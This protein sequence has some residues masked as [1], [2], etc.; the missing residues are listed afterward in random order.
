MC[1]GMGGFFVVLSTYTVCD[2]DGINIKSCYIVM[3]SLQIQISQIMSKIFTIIYVHLDQDG[4][5]GRL[6]VN[7]RASGGWT[8]DG[9]VVMSVDHLD[10]DTVVSVAGYGQVDQSIS[11]L[12]IQLEPHVFTTGQAHLVP[13]PATI[14]RILR[15]ARIVWVWPTRITPEIEP[16]F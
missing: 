11:E 5:M 9:T 2:V 16:I 13:A 14:I 8:L 3:R 1:G 6:V 7:Q 12:Q 10:D 15:C 4:I